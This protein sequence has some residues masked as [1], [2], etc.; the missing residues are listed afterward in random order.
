LRATSSSKL[1]ASTILPFSNTRMRS[2]LRIVARRWAITKVVRPSI[3]VSSACCSLRSVAASRAL[4]AR[5]LVFENGKIV[6]A[7]NFDELVAL[8]QRF[9]TLARAQFMA[10]E[11]EDDMPLAA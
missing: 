10:A 5:I 2:A 11:A 8:N 4:V 7:G 1:P 6:E 9:A 3:T